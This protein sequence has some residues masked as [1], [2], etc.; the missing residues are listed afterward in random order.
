MPNGGYFQYSL[1][2]YDF[3][4]YN[5]MPI[6]LFNETVLTAIAVRNSFSF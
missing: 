4:R 2:F 6:K 5:N 1:S 3:I